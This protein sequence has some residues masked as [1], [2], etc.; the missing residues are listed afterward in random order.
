MPDPEFGTE[1]RDEAGFRLADLPTRFGYLDDFG[2]GWTHDIEVLGPGEA[3]PGCGYGEGRCPPE[4][5]GGPTGWPAIVR[6]A[7]VVN[8]APF[9]QD[10]G[11]VMIRSGITRMMPTN[12]A[13]LHA[14]GGDTFR[15]PPAM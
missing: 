5:C 12:S 11:V 7:V 1:V 6:P 2:D 3:R 8:G 13:V 9:T 14:K 15:R 4:D 10:S